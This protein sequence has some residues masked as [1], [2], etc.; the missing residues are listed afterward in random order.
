MYDIICVFYLLISCCHECLSH[1]PYF[2]RLSCILAAR[3]E[4]NITTINFLMLSCSLLVE[5]C[6]DQ[7]SNMR[8][9]SL[10]ASGVFHYAFSKFRKTE[11]PVVSVWRAARYGSATI[12]VWVLVSCRLPIC[13]FWVKI[14]PTLPC[15]V[16]SRSVFHSVAR[17]P[18]PLHRHSQSVNSANAVMK[19]K[20]SAILHLWVGDMATL[21]VWHYKL[22][23]LI[24]P[25]YSNSQFSQ[26]AD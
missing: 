11:C 18:L 26:A 15:Y 22:N 16:S 12:S 3:V 10:H 14:G 6:W 19:L 20:L 4:A 23:K 1:L 24:P 7:R 9:S 8:E 25:L 21:T 5:A 13:I 17:I 2:L